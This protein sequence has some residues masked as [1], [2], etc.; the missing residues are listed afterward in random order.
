Y[1]E[2]GH[3]YTASRVASVTGRLRGVDPATHLLEREDLADFCA[4]LPDLAVELDAKT[5]RVKLGLWNLGWTFFDRCSS[6][7]VIHMA[8]SHHYLHGLTR[9]SAS[10]TTGAASKTLAAL[11]RNA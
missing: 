2:A 10:A 7:E 5:L 11:R 4:Q 8:V 1:S 9:G 6:A 3:F